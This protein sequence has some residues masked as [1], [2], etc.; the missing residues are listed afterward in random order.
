MPFGAFGHTDPASQSAQSQSGASP[1][2]GAFS[3]GG[4]Q[5]WQT[6][7][8]PQMSQ[9]MQ[10]PS[11]AASASQVSQPYAAGSSD[12]GPFAQA[13]TRPSAP[14]DT[15]TPPAQPTPAPTGSKGSS[16]FQPGWSSAN[17]G[18]TP[19]TRDLWSSP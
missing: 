9:A 3:S 7:A 6:G 14:T 18:G 16:L 5:P 12:V 15:I 8:V 2:T 10:I 13:S 19:Q 1:A 11:I 17:S 4:L